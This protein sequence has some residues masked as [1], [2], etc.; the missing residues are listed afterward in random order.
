VNRASPERG[1]PVKPAGRRLGPGRAGTGLHR[2]GAGGTGRDVTGPARPLAPARILLA[3]LALAA[4]PAAAD[5]DLRFAMPES[6]GRLDA[7]VFD[8]EAPQQRIGSAEISMLR[9][10]AAGDVEIAVQLRLDSGARSALHATLEPVDDD[11]ALR[12]RVQRTRTTGADGKVAIEMEAVHAEGFATC[13][14]GD[15]EPVRVELPEPDRMANV[16]VNLV[17]LPVAR[18]EREK[19][20]F[21]FLSCRGTARMLSVSAREVREIPDVPG[22]GSV[23]ELRYRFELGMILSR[24]LGPFLPTV[25][26]WLDPDAAEPWVGHRMP[27]YPGPGGPELLVVREGVSPEQLWP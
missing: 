7:G 27:L 3:A 16:P 25:V 4:P 17:L 15:E 10:E 8:S 24:I 14:T 20:E 9:A 12:P 26:F 23:S 18:G 13:T 11:R 6:F 21:E 2:G 22:H 1:G 5:S 19:V